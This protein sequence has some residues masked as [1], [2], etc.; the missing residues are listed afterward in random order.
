[1]RVAQAVLADLGFD[2]GRQAGCKVA[3]GE[4]QLG[5]EQRECTAFLGHVDR[6]QI[7][8]V[9]HEF[10]DAGRHGT[11]FRLVVTQ[12]K[13]GQRI[14]EAGVAEADATLVGGFLLLALERP[15]GGIEHVVEHAR[16]DADDFGESVEI[17]LGLFGESI[18]DVQRQVDRTQA[19]AAVGGSG[20][21]AQGL[22]A[23]ITSQ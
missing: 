11:S 22:V 14:T 3:T 16:R 4:V 8:G 17:E 5:I 7:G 12:A 21:S 13:H 15:V 19:A 23:S 10:A 2:V 6:V 20:C 1:V 18:L 9:A